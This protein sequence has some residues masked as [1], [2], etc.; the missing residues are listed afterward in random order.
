M[1]GYYN[2]REQYF[3]KT[4]MENIPLDVSLSDEHYNDKPIKYIT[5]CEDW[6]FN[7]ENNKKINIDELKKITDFNIFD[8][9]EV[10]K[11]DCE[12]IIK[13][14]LELC[15]IGKNLDQFTDKQKKDLNGV[16]IINKESS[17]DVDKIIEEPLYTFGEF[18]AEKAG[19]IA[20]KTLLYESTR[21]TRERKKNLIRNYKVISKDLIYKI[22]TPIIPKSGGSRR[23]KSRSRKNKR[24]KSIKRK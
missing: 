19:S 8:L 24:K 22:N 13:K 15:L 14:C 6:P 18:I 5:D 21:C 23:K 2:T 4:P 10:G 11:K 17:R 20:A 12:Y 1:S 3:Y 9:L 7:L 16:L